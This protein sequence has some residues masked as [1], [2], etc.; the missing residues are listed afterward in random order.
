[1]ARPFTFICLFCEDIREERS[2]QDTIIGVMPDNLTVSPL[3]GAIPRLGVYF[4]I[5]LEKDDNPQSIKLKLR[6]PGGL[7]LTMGSLDGLIVQAKADAEKN[8][9]PFAGLIARAVLSPVPISSPGRIEA[10][11][12]IDGAEYVCG[13]MNVQRAN[14]VPTPLQFTRTA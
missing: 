5:Q 7:E 4:R 10:I 3:P 14:E 11:A 1:M 12:E 2:G 9:I 8:G 6:V 13:A